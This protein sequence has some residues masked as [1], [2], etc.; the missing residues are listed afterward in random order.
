MDDRTA[1]SVNVRHN[2]EGL[3]AVFPPA[4]LIYKS[5]RDTLSAAAGALLTPQAAVE[6]GPAWDVLQ[7]VDGGL[8]GTAKGSDLMAG[9]INLVQSPNTAAHI[10]F[11]IAQ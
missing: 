5:T 1:P 11:V 9:G 4:Y 3:S 10:L 2:A 6:N 7:A 8:L